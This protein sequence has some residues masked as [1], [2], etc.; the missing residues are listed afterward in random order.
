MAVCFVLE[1]GS[2]VLTCLTVAM[3]VIWQDGG[4]QRNAP[5]RY[6][7]RASGQAFEINMYPS[8]R[9]CVPGYSSIHPWNTIPVFYASRSIHLAFSPGP[10]FFVNLTFTFQLQDKPCVFPPGT[11][12]HF[13][14]VKGSAFSTG[15]RFRS[16]VANSRSRAFRKP[17]LCTRKSPYEYRRACTWRGSNLRNGPWSS[18]GSYLLLID[19]RGHH[20]PP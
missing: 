8:E 18:R 5:R 3:V 11:H 16:N 10:F 12:H 4:R 7:S 6:I 2:S 20:D 19:H 17:T 1:V 14:R 15:C 9:C 13:Y